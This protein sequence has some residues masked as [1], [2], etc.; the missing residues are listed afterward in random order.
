MLLVL[1][2]ALISSLLI[3]LYCWQ[4][5]LSS[6]YRVPMNLAWCNKGKEMRSVGTMDPQCY[7][8]HSRILCYR[9][10][11]FGTMVLIAGNRP[12]WAAE[13]KTCI[14][15]TLKVCSLLEGAHKTPTAFYIKMYVK[16]TRDFS[17]NAK[18]NNYSQVVC[19][20]LPPVWTNKCLCTAIM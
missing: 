7:F 1:G 13:W 3:L 16:E 12:R 8:C 18:N 11:L 9:E 4:W 15:T 17:Q 20:F 2:G 19:S 14:F 10:Q 5:L 6:N